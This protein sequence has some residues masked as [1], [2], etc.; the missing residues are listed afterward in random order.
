MLAR[1]SRQISRASLRLSSAAQ[2]EPNLIVEK[3]E[4]DDE[5][6]VIWGLNR[7]KLFG[8]K[9]AMSRV[10]MVE[11]M[12]AFEDLRFDSNAR[13]LIVRSTSPGIFCAGADLKERKDIPP[14]EVGP[15]V[16]RARKFFREFQEMPIPTICALDGHALGGGIEWAMGHDLRTAAYNAKM[17][18]TETKL[19]IIPGGGGTQNLTRLVGVAKA[20][21]LAFTARMIGGEEAERIGLVNK[22]V[23]QNENGDA[24]YV[25]ALELAREIQPNGPV[26]VR[27]A[28][29]A[30]NYGSEVDLATALAIEQQCYAQVIPTDDRM[31]GIMAFLQKRKPVYTGQ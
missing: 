12:E 4:G 31:E 21:E 8:N 23:P 13:C 10:L 27:M 28:K 6:I 22:A 2:T 15:L 25:E 16:A 29:T 18:V 14:E 9:N 20:K 11:I 24:A 5:G 17:G 3:L 19:A 26:A 7:D 30:I 1:F